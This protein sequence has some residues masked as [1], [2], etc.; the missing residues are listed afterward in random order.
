ME[1]ISKFKSVISGTTA[2]HY[3]SQISLKADAVSKRATKRK[4]RTEAERAS[5]GGTTQ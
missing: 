2:Y 3:S 5:R 4:H 1:A